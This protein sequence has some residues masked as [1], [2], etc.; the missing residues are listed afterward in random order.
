MPATINVDLGRGAD[1]STHI[2]PIAVIVWAA[3]RLGDG[4]ND[5]QTNEALSGISYDVGWRSTVGGIRR[6]TPLWSYVIPPTSL[7]KKAVVG[8]ALLRLCARARFGGNSTGNVALTLQV[9]G[10]RRVTTSSAT[11]A[12]YDGSNPWTGIYGPEAGTDYT[13]TAAGSRVVT[14][15]EL[16]ALST[17]QRYYLDIP[18]TEEVQYAL[19]RGIPLRLL[20]PTSW[21]NI[22][23]GSTTF[24]L[25]FDRPSDAGNAALDHTYLQVSYRPYLGIVGAQAIAGRPRDL[26]RLYNPASADER[27]HISPDPVDI[28]STSGWKKAFVQLFGR[29]TA[30]RVYLSC[31]SDAT[32]VVMSASG[33]RALRWMQRYDRTGVTELTP[34]GTYEMRILAGGVTYE[35][36]YQDPDTLVWETLQEE[37]TADE[38]VDLTSDHVFVRAGAT[39]VRVL[40]IRTDHFSTTSGW[41]EDETATQVIRADPRPSTYDSDTLSLVQIAP[42]TTSGGD[43]EDTTVGLRTLSNCRGGQQVYAA[44][45]V[46]SGK[47]NIPVGDASDYV[48]GEWVDVYHGTTGVVYRAEIEATYPIGDPDYGTWPEE[49]RLTVDL[50]VTLPAKSFVTHGLIQ[51]D[52]SEPTT[53]HLAAGAGIGATTIVVD[54]AIPGL[55][56]SDQI[57]LTDL[58]SNAIQTVTVTGSPSTAIAFTPALTATFGLTTEVAVDESDSNEPFFFR[59]AIP[60]GLEQGQFLGLLSLSSKKVI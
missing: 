26:S 12:Y 58:T 30:R 9:H 3:T 8:L 6:H 40:K 31:L 17:S 48:V 25:Q 11:G 39:S 55:A 7:P 50:G 59:G 35:V 24:S 13:L 38:S 34:S 21:G 56:A 36:N 15:A 49:V 22:S 19:D 42:P 16:D 27:D 41:L 14:G 52:L 33:G 23:G 57:T 1:T 51:G 5:V 28:G 10:V 54:E 32:A 45:H 46:V 20:I 18:I 47:T 44:S 37:G 60:D 4:V 53:T 2:N 43:T 29:G